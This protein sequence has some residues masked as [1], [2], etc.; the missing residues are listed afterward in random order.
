LTALWFLF[1]GKSA[2]IM[3]MEKLFA[4][5]LL[6]GATIPAIAW[7][8]E[9][10]DIAMVVSFDR[11]ESIDRDEAV[12]QITGLIYTLRHP[13]FHAAVASGYYGRIGLSA[14]TWSSFV[15]H[16]VILPWMMIGGP[17]DGEVA[18]QW[19]GK[20]LNRKVAAQHGTQTDV[21]YGL[22]IGRRQMHALPWAA[23]KRVI[24]IVSDGISNTGHIAM[25]DRD[26]TWAQGIAIN[27]LIIAQGSAI[28]VLRN[29]FRDNVIA[30]PSAFVQLA[31]SNEEF[32][33]ATLRKMVLEIA[34]LNAE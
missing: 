30:G 8:G 25:V 1:P 21:A 34:L 19:L 26:K 2:K 6:I 28:R 29:Y 9:K 20:F 15:R 18:A 10:V 16:E 31:Q 27:A 17:E 11:S 33:A 3:V 13:R 7:S 22:E 32:A 14:L 23:V 4:I 12:A 24:N 5:L